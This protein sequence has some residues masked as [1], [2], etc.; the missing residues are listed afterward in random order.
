L[1]SIWRDFNGSDGAVSKQQVGKNPAA[2][3]CKK[4]ESSEG[5]QFIGSF[6]AHGNILSD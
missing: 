4:V 5:L 6:M 1:P 2:A 3:S